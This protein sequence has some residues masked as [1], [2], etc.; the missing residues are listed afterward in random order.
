MWQTGPWGRD[1]FIRTSNA[2]HIRQFIGLDR[3]R[4]AADRRRPAVPSD[5]ASLSANAGAKCG[6][7]LHRQRQLRELQFANLQ[8]TLDELI[9]DLLDAGQLPFLSGAARAEAMAEAKAALLLLPRP[10][11]RALIKGRAKITVEPVRFFTSTSIYLTGDTA[12]GLTSI[13]RKAKIAG[14]CGDVARVTLHETGHLLDQCHRPQI[15]AG[16]QWRQIW[17]SEVAAGRVETFGNEH[18]FPHEFFAASFSKFFG[19]RAPLSA[20]VCNFMAELTNA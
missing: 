15:S 12:I 2:K 18:L 17:E 5:F 19:N 9:R 1:F 8:P 14:E 20:A 11:L 16:P 6:R 7:D 13:D 4:V 10:L 3:P